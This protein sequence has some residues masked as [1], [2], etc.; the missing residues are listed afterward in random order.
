MA[1]VGRER[2]T[3]RQDERDRDAVGRR[4]LAHFTESDR[5]FLAAARPGVAELLG[6]RPGVVLDLLGSEEVAAALFPRPPQPSDALAMVSPALAFAVAVHRAAEEQSGSLYVPEWVGPRQRVP[7]F[8]GPELAAFLAEPWHRLFLVE[9]LASYARVASGSYL[10]RTAHGWRRRR[11]S[12][13]DPVQL[14]GLLHAVSPAE[15]AG[16]YR[17]LGDLALFLTGVFPDHTATRAFRPLDAQR[18]LRLVG[19]SHEHADRGAVDLLQWL[20]PRW[21]RQAVA[22]VPFVTADARILQTMADQFVNARRILTVV[23]DR[24]LFPVGNPW[25]PWN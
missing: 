13:L 22:H 23:A 7:V 25:F 19:E 11:Y 5:R 9:L 4:Y 24:Y 18:L 16:V 12:E 1:D 15:Q 20:G 21:Y 6:R 8:A 14:A 10:T 17:R 2:E 3:R